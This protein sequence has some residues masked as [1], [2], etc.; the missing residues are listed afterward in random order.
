MMLRAVVSWTAAQ[1][2]EVHL[3]LLQPSFN[4]HIN[5]LSLWAS[6]PQQFFMRY[7][8]SQ[9]YIFSVS[10]Q[11]VSADFATPLYRNQIFFTRPSRAHLFSC[12]SLLSKSKQNN[13]GL[14]PTSTVF[15]TPLQEIQICSQATLFSNAQDHEKQSCAKPFS[16]QNAN[17]IALDFKSW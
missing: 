10:F 6:K 15:A 8:L 5:S 14:K 13:L 9:W 7:S 3:L 2:L 11:T 4:K 17:T 12:N 1:A 16:L